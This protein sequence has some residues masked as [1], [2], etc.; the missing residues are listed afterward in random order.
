M[1]LITCLQEVCGQKIYQGV[2]LFLIGHGCMSL[3]GPGGKYS[4]LMGCLY[5]SLQ[6]V[7]L[8]FSGNLGMDVAKVQHP[9]QY[10]IKGCFKFGS[11]ILFLPSE[12]YLPSIIMVIFVPPAKSNSFQTQ[13]MN[14]NELKST[15]LGKMGN[16]YGKKQSL[17]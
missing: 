17:Q 14:H 9:G 12:M 16:S 1:C 7:T 13:S 10:L 6:N 3:I 5:N 4:G 15:V 11:K 2:C 8:S